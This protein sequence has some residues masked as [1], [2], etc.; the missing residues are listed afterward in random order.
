MT[1]RGFLTLLLSTLFVTSGCLDGLDCELITVNGPEA[2]F[3]VCMV[4]LKLAVTF[5]A[6]LLVLN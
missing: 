6:S 2:D 4:L 3:R 5:Y 1:N